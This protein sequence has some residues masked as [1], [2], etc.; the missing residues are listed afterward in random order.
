MSK[1][2]R[3]L[4]QLADNPEKSEKLMRALDKEIEGRV[5]KLEKVEK[6]MQ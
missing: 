4:T 3:K 6:R 2:E 1:H 5:K